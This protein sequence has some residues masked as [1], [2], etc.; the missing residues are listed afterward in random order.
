[1]MQNTTA[2]NT[3]DTLSAAD[4]DAPRRIIIIGAGIIGLSTAYYLSSHQDYPNLPPQN[5]TVLDISPNL[6]SC[7]SGRAGGFLA[8]DWF[9]PASSALGELSFRLHRELADTNDGRKR[10]GYSPSAAFSLA[11][12]R[13][14]GGERGER[15]DD[16]LRAGT[17]RID[18]SAS[19]DDDSDDDAQRG[20]VPD[21]LNPNGGEVE[22]SGKGD[23]TG[24]VDPHDLCQFL[25]EE[26]G[27]RGVTIR[28][29]VTPLKLVRAAGGE[30][31]GLVISKDGAAGVAEAKEETLS[32]SHILISAGPWSGRVF[33][34]LFPESTYRL[35]ISS[36]AG[37]SIIVRSPLHQ[38]QDIITDDENLQPSCHA[39]FASIKGLSWHPEVFSRANG[40]IYLAGLNSAEI[41]LPEIATDVKENESD[42]RELKGLLKDMIKQGDVASVVKT[43]LCHRPVTP[44]GTPILA[45]FPDALLGDLKTKPGDGNGGIFVSAGH[46]PW[47]I[48]QSLGTGKLMAE[49]MMGVKTSIDVSELGLQ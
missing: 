5:I 17:S 48:S 43:G 28:Y 6:F 3:A 40:D 1:M 22:L 27:Q 23:T 4:K 39:V 16:W 37:H 21:W 14:T 38:P 47:G 20:L 44:A 9:A 42:I 12:A 25:L 19:G 2:D 33:Q 18:A 10:W 15:G 11:S 26:V 13:K 32:C 46:G 31:E 49:M 8:K 29:P 24:Q 35:P 30:L 36:L 7:A 41:P 34:K 45:R